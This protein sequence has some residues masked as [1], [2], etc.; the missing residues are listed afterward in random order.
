MVETQLVE[1]NHEMRQTIAKLREKVEQYDAEIEMQ[2]TPQLSELALVQKLQEQENTIRLL[3]SMIS[4]LQTELYES[5]KSRRG[6]S[7]IF[8]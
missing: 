8:P 3:K 6:C 5:E 4:R 1:Q 7:L 2:P